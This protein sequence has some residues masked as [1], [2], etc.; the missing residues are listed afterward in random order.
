VV[1]TI[2][3]DGHCRLWFAGLLLLAIAALVAA[4]V[5]YQNASAQ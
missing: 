2:S 5:R 3:P 4:G 1:L